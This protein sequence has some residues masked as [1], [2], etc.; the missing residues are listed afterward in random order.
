MMT[1]NQRIEHQSEASYNSGMENQLSPDQSAALAASPNAKIALVD[2][3]TKQRYVL[4]PENEY[5]RLQDLDAIRQ[6]ISRMESGEGQTLPEAM[7]EIRRS[8]QSRS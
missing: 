3:S 6:G 4:V 5:S 7:N 8:L 1:L 2:P